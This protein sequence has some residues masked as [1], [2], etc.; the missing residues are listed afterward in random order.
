MNIRPQLERKIEAK[1]KEINEVEAQLREAKAY[2]QGLQEVLRMLPRDATSEDKPD[3][4][5]EQLLRTGS[6]M[7]KTR[8]LLRKVGKPLHITDILKGIGK[9]INKSSRVSVSGSL[10]NYARRNEI[11]TRTAPNTFG[12]I[13]FEQTASTTEM[14]DEPPEGFGT[15]LVEPAEEITDSDVPW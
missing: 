4:S 12:L 6:D 11:F 9:E 8:D 5:S 15:E 1:V 13:E 3:R 2:L 7:A 14:G 10:G